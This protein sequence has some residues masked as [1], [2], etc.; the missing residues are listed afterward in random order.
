M[1]DEKSYKEQYNSGSVKGGDQVREEAERALEEVKVQVEWEK[2][3]WEI[4]KNLFK[5]MQGNLQMLTPERKFQENPEFWKEHDK[6]QA[7]EH[8]KQRF[9]H[10]KKMAQLQRAVDERLKVVNELKGE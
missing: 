5:L 2:K 7:L 1:A 3:N 10:E 8:E 6:L 4:Q 9:M